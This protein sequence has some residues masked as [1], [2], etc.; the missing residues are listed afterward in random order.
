[1]AYQHNPN[2]YAYPPGSTPSYAQQQQQAQYPQQQQ[3][4]YAQPTP[5]TIRNPFAPPPPAQPTYGA[6]NAYD[7]EYE[8]Q[9]AA[10]QSAYAPQ[11]DLQADKKAIRTGTGKGENPN[12]TQLGQRSAAS[13]STTTTE[14]KSPV[15]ALPNPNAPEKK[16][17]V[18]RQ[19]GG[20]T[21]ADA[22]LTIWD[23]TQFRI[24]VGNLA[25]EVTD[26]SLA[27]AFAAYG[28]SKAR[29]VR[30][31]RTTKSKGYGF[32]AFED[33]E[34]GFQAA[35]EMVGKYIGSHPVTVKRSKVDL[36]VVEEKERGRGGK[37]DKKNRGREKGKGNGQ[38]DVLG[39]K[40]GA[41]VEKPG[42]KVPGG[43]YKVIG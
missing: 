12:L 31:K 13:T 36:R 33:G 4:P 26:D 28:V 23:P 3:Q 40:P 20:Q 14:T 15:A 35:R 27:K 39:A 37:N 43:A 41:G 2:Q 18:L 1:M 11:Q 22:T 7:P 42:A 24:M 17:T 19:G 34:R 8:A 21:W 29:V 10:W 30:D 16:L 9:I 38:E 5:P 25:G 6:P 32:V